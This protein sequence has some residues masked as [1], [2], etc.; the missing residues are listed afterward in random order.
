[1]VYGSHGIRLLDSSDAIIENLNVHDTGD[2][3]ISANMPESLYQRVTLRHNH[4]HHTSGTGECF[5]LGC[6]DGDCVMA[7]S[8]IA[9]NLCHDTLS[10]SQ[11]DGIE[12]KSGS[13]GN[14]V[15][16]NV[17]YN[18]YYPAFTMYGT[19][20]KPVNILEGNICWNQGDNGIQ[21]VG[22][23]IVRNNIVFNAGNNGIQ[24][25]PS[26][27]A[28]VQNLTIVHNTVVGAA[29]A[30]LKGN[31]WYSSATGVIVAN[32]AFYCAST[33]AINLVNGNAAGV[34]SGNIAEGSVAGI[35]T[36]YSTGSQ[37]AD[38]VDPASHNAFPTQSGALVGAGD[39]DYS[40][41]VDFDGYSRSPTTC[42]AGAYVYHSGGPVWTVT[43]DFKD[44]SAEEESSSGNNDDSGSN[45]SNTSLANFILPTISLIYLCC[46]MVL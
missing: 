39:N 38:L 5:Y 29:Y 3:G 20:G 19:Y 36:G 21:T 32:N 4:V 31:D 1:M 43:T 18:T 8:L 22:E 6:N 9:N 16:D 25:K 7:D 23:I 40:T 14:I 42:D 44:T 26:Q 28:Y 2:V 33:A 15:R 17:V 30:C 27:G 12:L 13:Y 46:V 24:A 11:G 35:S 10:T 37:A 34:F 45:N 41:S